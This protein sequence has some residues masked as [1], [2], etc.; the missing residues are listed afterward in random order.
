MMV[1]NALNIKSDA[2]NNTASSVVKDRKQ[3]ASA[4]VDAGIPSKEPFVAGPVERA[5]LAILGMEEVEQLVTVHEE[6]AQQREIFGGAIRKGEERPTRDLFP[7]RFDNRRSRKQC[8]LGRRGW[9]LSRLPAGAMVERRRTH[10][11]AA[12]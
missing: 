3:C 8:L 10:L 4:A 11:R 1:Y 5:I 2:I 12:K 9:R 7:F 6:E